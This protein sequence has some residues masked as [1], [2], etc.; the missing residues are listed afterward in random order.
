MREFS[1]RELIE[2]PI[3]RMESNKI[4]ADMVQGNEW[5]W[6][7]LSFMLPTSILD[8]IKATPI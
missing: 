5:N 4:L 2:G 6:N 3:N 8:K 1:P 7:A